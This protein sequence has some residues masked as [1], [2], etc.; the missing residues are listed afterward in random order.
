M[1]TAVL[2]LGLFGCAAVFVGIVMIMRAR[3]PASTH[4]EDTMLRDG[5]ILAVLVPVV[6]VIWSARLFAKERVGHG[7]AV[8]TISIA[9]FLA[10]FAYAVA[11]H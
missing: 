3:R 10:Y 5:I 6:G 11:N 2:L 9:V 4:D 8:L 1:E 7:L